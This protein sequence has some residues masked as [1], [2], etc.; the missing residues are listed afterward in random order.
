M[1]ARPLQASKTLLASQRQVGGKRT[2][3]DDHE[4]SGLGSS[5][6]RK[7]SRKDLG[8]DM[9]AWPESA[10]GLAAGE[11]WNGSERSYGDYR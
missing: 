1:I 8:P 4:I 3:G 5:T 2:G 10:L 9:T 7:E 6:E 11:V